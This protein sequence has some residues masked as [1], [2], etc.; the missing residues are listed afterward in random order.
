M[1][2]QWPAKRDISLILQFHQV[3]MGRLTSMSHVLCAEPQRMAEVTDK[4]RESF[5][6]LE[7][8]IDGGAH[9]GSI[10][11]DCFGQSIWRKGRAALV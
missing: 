10:R 8:K 6:M 5:Q 3:E 9:A 2:A 11:H 4:R 1:S 7:N